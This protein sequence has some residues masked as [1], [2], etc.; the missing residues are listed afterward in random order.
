MLKN[1]IDE[2]RDRLNAMLAKNPDPLCDEVLSLSKALDEMIHRYTE[3]EM[4]LK[5]KA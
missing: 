2:M 4:E 3:L 5:S 1:I